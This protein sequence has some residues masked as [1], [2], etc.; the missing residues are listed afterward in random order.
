MEVNK[1]ADKTN[2]L[3]P[4]KKTANIEFCC[5]WGTSKFGYERLSD[6]LLTE[7]KVAGPPNPRCGITGSPKTSPTSQLFQ[8]QSISTCTEISVDTVKVEIA[9]EPQTQRAPEGINYN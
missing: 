6:N 8:P 7:M 9:L 4:K 3:L 5:G 2:S 1:A